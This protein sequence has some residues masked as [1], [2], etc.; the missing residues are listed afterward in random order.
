MLKNIPSILSPELLAT[1][2]EMGHSDVIVLGDAN[3]PGKRF[4][5][6]GNCKFLRADGISGTAL[7]EAILQVIPTD[8]YADTPVMLM[9][10]MECDKDLD[11]PIWKDYE[12][13]VAKNDSRGKSAVGYLERFAF[14]E[15]AKK[16]YCIVQTGET[17]IYANVI[18]QK[19]VIK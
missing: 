9:Q 1:L 11:I 17:Q 8:S 4:A 14:Y 6:E 2:C 10:T 3:F 5:H 13:I 7:L 12:A 16:A 18:I 19:G 15:V